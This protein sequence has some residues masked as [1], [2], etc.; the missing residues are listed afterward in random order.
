MAETLNAEILQN[1]GKCID[2]LDLKTRYLSPDG[3]VYSGAT[4]GSGAGTE[5]PYGTVGFTTGVVGAW[6]KI[7]DINM[8]TANNRN[9]QLDLA[10]QWGTTGASS[11]NA[12]ACI[13]RLGIRSGTG[14]AYSSYAFDVIAGGNPF[15]NIL[16]PISLYSD[17]QTP[18]SFSL[19]AQCAV[20]YGWVRVTQINATD[21]VSSTADSTSYNIVWNR[22]YRQSSMTAPTG[23]LRPGTYS[24]ED[25]ALYFS[26]QADMNTKL[27]AQSNNS[28]GT[29]F[30]VGAVTSVL[31][32][33]ATSST[34]F[35]TWSRLSAI[36]VSLTYWQFS[37][38]EATLI[39]HRTYYNPTTGVVE[40][41]QNSS[42]LYMN[43]TGMQTVAGAKT[44]SS[45]V[46]V[47]TPTANAHAATKLYV[48]TAVAGGGADNV[49]ISG[50]Q[51]I[52]GAKTFSATTNFQ[53]IN[54][55]GILN[56]LNQTGM[57]GFIQSGGIATPSVNAGTS[58]DDLTL[59]M[60][61]TVNVR[62][63]MAI[64]SGNGSGVSYVYPISGTSSTSE[65]TLGHPRN[66][67]MQWDGYFKALTLNGET[68]TSWPGGSSDPT[69]QV[70]IDTQT[71]PSGATGWTGCSL[72]VTK[73]GKSVHVDFWGMPTSGSTTSSFTF[74]GL[75]KPTRPSSG[76]GAYPCAILSNVTSTLG[77]CAMYVDYTTGDLYISVA[78]SI[79]TQQRGS[80]TYFTND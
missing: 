57:F 79:T 21:P 34:V 73:Y 9:A 62:A 67:D 39:T 56:A 29:F 37:S 18:V 23:T 20:N 31:S 2:D 55:Q 61:G 47:A 78:G 63:G 51:T 5:L 49:T 69:I 40:N 80:L 32:K 10:I 19:W 74:T 64:H 44:F 43:L 36:D 33:G 35:G 15:T 72:Y 30:A 26:S 68:I 66:E 3:S 17:D 50:A 14:G 13:A 65:T 48:D 53:Q 27:L 8:T 11:T 22:L 16:A 28:S 60:G 1:V 59:W 76:T 7:A 70:L 46:S 71:L 58:G 41:Y 4:S 77:T 75:P 25:S 24:V 42:M 38:T 54:V 45:P 12:G 6:A 52:T